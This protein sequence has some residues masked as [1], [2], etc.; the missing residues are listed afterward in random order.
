[1]NKQEEFGESLL[2]QGV[3]CIQR[4]LLD[5]ER[6]FLF[7]AVRHFSSFIPVTTDI[8]DYVARKSPLI[9][10]DDVSK[11]EVFSEFDDEEVEAIA[12]EDVDADC[13]VDCDVDIDSTDSAYKSFF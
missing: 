6:L 9:S 3:F 2:Q 5:K 11:A 10:E 13:D 7:S 4:Q 12:S 1:M 8:S